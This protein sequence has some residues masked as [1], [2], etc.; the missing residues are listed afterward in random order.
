MLTRRA[1]DLS[2]RIYLFKSSDSFTPQETYYE[3][4]DKRDAVL[5]AVYE[6]ECIIAF[7]GTKPVQSMEINGPFDIIPTFAAAGF[8]DILQNLGT[9]MKQ[10]LV[11][12]TN[13]NKTCSVGSS[14][15][16]GYF[17]VY[18]HSSTARSAPSKGTPSFEKHI[19]QECVTQGLPLVFTGHSQGAALAQFAALRYEAQQPTTIVFAPAPAFFDDCP[20]VPHERVINFV[21]TETAFKLG[22]EYDFV[23]F[24]DVL[25]RRILDNPN[26]SLWKL[27]PQN[28]K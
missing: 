17:N 11:S 20:H 5:V 14:F 1:V 27:L 21:N 23:P 3:S 7:R 4:T 13:S 19:D 28:D 6:N 24:A 25:L 8:E 16:N 12:K 26:L 9:A 15:Y 22:I 2:N 18:N 10:N